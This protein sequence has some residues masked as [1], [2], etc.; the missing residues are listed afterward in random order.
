MVLVK[1]VVCRTSSLDH[2]S[3]SASVVPS[4]QCCVRTS[5]YGGRGT[6]E[7]VLG[8]VGLTQKVVVM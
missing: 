1:L 6:A 8:F 7:H 5:L 4:G 2:Q 3:F